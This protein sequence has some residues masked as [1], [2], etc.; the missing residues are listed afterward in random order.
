M[1]RL[2]LSGI[3]LYSGYWPAAQ[4]DTRFTHHIFNPA[5]VNPA[6]SGNQGAL[7]AIVLFR[8]QWT[9]LSGHPVTEFLGADLPLYQINGGAGFYILNEQT[10]QER[11]TH[12]RV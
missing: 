10:G 2:L 12:L 1:K 4:Q 11:N 9:Q 7:N 8:S 3:L 6:A 5:H